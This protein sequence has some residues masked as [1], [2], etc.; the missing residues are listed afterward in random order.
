MKGIRMT[1]VLHVS[2]LDANLQVASEGDGEA[3][4]ETSM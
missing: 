1:D 3:S 4:T 2:N